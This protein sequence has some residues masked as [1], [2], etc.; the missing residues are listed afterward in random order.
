MNT[1]EIGKK[2]LSALGVDSIYAYVS[3][4][5][6]KIGNMQHSAGILLTVWS[7]IMT[8]C[9]GYISATAAEKNKPEKIIIFSSY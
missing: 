3:T 8:I 2:Y 1:D 6:T 9:F 4:T 7:L 5:W